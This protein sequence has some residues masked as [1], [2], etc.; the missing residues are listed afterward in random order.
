MST[1]RRPFTLRVDTAR[2]VPVAWLDI[3]VDDHW[4][5]SA[6]LVAQGRRVVVREVHIAPRPGVTLP[7]GGLAAGAVAFPR[8]AD[9]LGFFVG[10]LPFY[11]APAG[12]RVRPGLRG[13]ERVFPFLVGGEAPRRWA[14]ADRPGKRPGRPALTDDE[15]LRASAAY[16]DALRRQSR[17][18]TADAARALGETPLRMR[19]LLNTARERALLTRPL[20]GRARGELTPRARALLRARQKSARRGRD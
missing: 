7:P 12:A 13:L 11:W 15:L 1:R 18:P 3:N 6:A 16:V 20:P 14:R 17:R 5:V 19:D 9:V 8:F 4:S 10:A 2:A